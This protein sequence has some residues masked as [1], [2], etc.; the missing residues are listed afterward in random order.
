MS[1]PAASLSLDPFCETNSSV[2]QFVGSTLT[3]ALEMLVK[4][5]YLLGHQL[6]IEDGA[7]LSIEVC[8]KAGAQ[9][10]PSL[11]PAP[12]RRG[13][14]TPLLVLS[15]QTLRLF[16]PPYVSDLSSQSPT[17]VSELRWPLLPLS[18]LE[19]LT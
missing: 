7:F 4:S 6:T 11:K 1:K 15:C 16:P 8:G 9:V 5:A 2:T 18:S 12:P 19:P 13:V 17:F 10:S 14:F 3:A